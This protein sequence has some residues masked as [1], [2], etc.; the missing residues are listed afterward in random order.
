VNASVRQPKLH[1]EFLS[2]NALLTLRTASSLATQTGRQAISERD[3]LAAILQNKANIITTT[4]RSAG[5]DPARL[6]WNETRPA[7]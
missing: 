7:L 3:I 6:L 1:R 5:V 2:E 4:L